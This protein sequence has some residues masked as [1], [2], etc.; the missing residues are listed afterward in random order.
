M[1]LKRASSALNLLQYKPE[2]A[3]STDSALKS[4]SASFTPLTKIVATLG[5]ATSTYET[6]SQVV[7]AGVNVIRMNFSHG[8]HEFHEQLYKIVRK[9][10]EDLGKEVAIIA[11]LQ[12]PKV[13]TNTF[14]GGKITIKRGDKVSIVGSPEPGKPGVITTKFTP[15]ITHCNVGEPVLI[16][17][18]L[19][20][21]IVQ[22][23]NPNELVCLVEQGGDVKD[24]KG[25][26]LPA[27]DLGPLPA[28]TEKDIEDAK[29]VLDTLEVDFFALSFVRKPQDVLD[30][31]H[32][33]EAKGKEMR[34]IVKIE[35][36][37]AIKNLDEILAVSDACMVARGDL[38]VEVGTAKVP[39][40]QKHIIRHCLEMGLPVITATQMLES[41]THNPTPT[42][43]EATDV[44]NAIYDGT[45]CVML[46]G[47]T[48]A[49]EF[50]VE[51]VHTMQDIILET[52][53]HLRDG[54]RSQF[55]AEL[56]N[57]EKQ[58][59]SSGKTSG[60]SV[61][62][63]AHM[64]ARSTDAV[65][66]GC[67]SDTGNAAIRLSTSRP[68]IPIYVFSSSLSTI[69]RMCLTRGAYGLMMSSIPPAEEIFSEMEKKMKRMGFIKTGENVVYTAGLPTLAHATTNT[70]HVKTVE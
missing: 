33:I 43:A 35:K 50:P 55:E 45:D 5:P 16:D 10:A 66:F 39:C 3:S 25:I 41:M 18:G 38:A 37:E 51:T 17:D 34:I 48:A 9:V 29:F 15:M 11:D 44:A 32:L 42:R 30:L 47:E 28:L 40:L 8:T 62:L 68:A 19:I 20:R 64:L 31:R 13:R 14:P 7:T 61:G 2:F 60:F 54:K 26:N 21:L 4:P 49:G 69:R 59:D 46:S 63:A 24:H 12:G 57:P 36:P 53:F 67:V 6:I 23:K 27:T 56:F 52:E 70:V 58:K 1:S 22:E 65:A